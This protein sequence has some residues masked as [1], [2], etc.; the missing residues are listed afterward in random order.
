MFD[1]EPAFCCL[2]VSHLCTVLWF[3][4]TCDTLKSASLSQCSL[5]QDSWCDGQELDVFTVLGKAS[6]I[7]SHTLRKISAS[8]SLWEGPVVPLE[9]ISA[10]RLSGKEI[11]MPWQ[12]LV[13]RGSLWREREGGLCKVVLS[14]ANTVPPAC[15]AKWKFSSSLP[16]NVMWQPSIFSCKGSYEFSSLSLCWSKALLLLC[17]EHEMVCWWRLIIQWLNLRVST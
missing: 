2:V 7:G 8:L 3:A 14:Q 17:H 1:S 4:I 13:Q 9:E 12:R 10:Q 15:L 11:Q 6:S 5:K 16:E